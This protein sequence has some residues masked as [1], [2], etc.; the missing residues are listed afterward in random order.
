MDDQRQHS[1]YILI[2]TFVAV[3]GGIDALA[4]FQLAEMPDMSAEAAN[5]GWL[6]DEVYRSEDGES[7]IVVTRFQSLEVREKWSEM[8]RL[9]RHVER[10]MPLVKGVTSEPVTFLAV[11]GDSRMGPTANV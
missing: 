7:L 6:G 5:Y 1:W 8:A 2:N 3:E 11:H 10:L 4:E 9:R